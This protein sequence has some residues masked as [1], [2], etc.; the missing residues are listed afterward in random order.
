[1]DA[2]VRVPRLFNDYLDIAQ[3]TQT[4][5]KQGR[6]SEYSSLRNG[7]SISIFN[8]ERPLDAA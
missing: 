3:T 6:Q 5:R 4:L 8:E 7:T 2:S 1:M